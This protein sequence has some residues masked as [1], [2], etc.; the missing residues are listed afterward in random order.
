MRTQLGF[1]STEFYMHRI[2]RLSM[3]C[4]AAAVTMSGCKPEQVTATEDIPTAGVRFINAVPDSSGAFGLDFRYVDSPVESNA[5]FRISFRNSPTTTAGVTA[6][7][8]VQYKGARAGNRTFSIFLNDTIQAIA[9]TKLKDST[10]NLV[11]G[12]NYTAIMWGAGRVPGQ[13]KLRIIDESALPD[14]GAK[15]AL[16]VINAT[17]QPIDASQYVSTGAVPATPTWAN[18]APYSVSS[19]VLV[20]PAQ[21][22]YNVRSAGTATNLF[23]DMLAMIGAPAFST[24]GASGKLDIAALV[25]TTVAGSAISLIVYPRS[26]ALSRTPQTAPFQVPAGSFVWD[27]RPPIGF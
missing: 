6:S 8:T 20:D 24:A 10:L 11:A 1:L 9:S 4:L 17:D 25:G 7:A 27:R 22:R 5:Q 19:Y 2:H 13:M 18:V 23:T 12:K 15:V 26:T 14:P 3:F 16:R 21:Y